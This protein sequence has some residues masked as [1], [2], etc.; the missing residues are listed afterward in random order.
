MAVI[1]AGLGD[2]D[3]VIVELERAYTERAPAMFMITLE[4][5]FAGLRSDPRFVALA[6]KVG[7]TI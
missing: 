2:N 4:P 6:R 5:V 3:Q 1:Q 7:L